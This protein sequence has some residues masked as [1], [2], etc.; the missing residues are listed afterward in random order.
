M[1][2]IIRMSILV[3]LLVFPGLARAQEAA[4]V[5]PVTLPGTERHRLL[6]SSTET[7]Y[8]IFVALP[9]GYGRSDS[10]TYPV[11]Y[12]LDGNWLFAMVVQTH[13]MMRLLTQE[14]REAI[15]VGIG[16]PVESNEELLALRFMD[17]TPT[18][19]VAIEE[20]FSANLGRPVGTGGAAA[21]LDALAEEIMPFVEGTYR[22]G[23]ERM[24]A[25]FSLG[26]LF[27]AYAL[28]HHPR[29]FQSY[30][31]ASPSLFWDNE[32]AFAYEERYASNRENLQARVFISAGALEGTLMTSVQRLAAVLTQ[33]RY[34]D[35][36]L[37]AQVFEDETH[38]SGVP[39]TLSRGLRLLLSP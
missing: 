8:D 9:G 22:V 4:S 30:L 19:D 6:S 31:I 36:E 26:G 16:Y 12:V 20:R 1:A 18:R 35:L 25:G 15:I 39:A 23:T 10:T 32:V 7:E 24:I 11:V 33:R 37:T 2:R 14:V 17:L 28:L 5:G 21:F 3:V 34:P 38:F 13:R 29:L 27:G